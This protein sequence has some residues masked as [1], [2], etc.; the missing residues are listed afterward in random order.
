M[1]S[2]S[3]DIT[4][5]KEHFSAIGSRKDI[6]SGN[7]DSVYAGTAENIS[8]KALDKDVELAVAG[9]LCS[10]SYSPF[11][12]TP[13]EVDMVDVGSNETKSRC[14]GQIVYCSSA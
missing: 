4:A 6:W 12:I 7:A 8:I 9:C 3:C 5:G 13:E 2:G 14:F 10:K 1:L 11:R